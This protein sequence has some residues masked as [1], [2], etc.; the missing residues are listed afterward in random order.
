M[1][2]RLNITRDTFPVLTLLKQFFL[3]FS[4]QG[5][6]LIWNSFIKFYCHLFKFSM[7]NIS[8]VQEK[9]CFY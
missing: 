3:S 9:E 5:R 2:F 1:A 7:T 4:T 8:Y 6:K